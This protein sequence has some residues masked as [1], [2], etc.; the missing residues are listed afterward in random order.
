VLKKV[1]IGILV[2]IILAAAGCGIYIY[3]LDWNKHKTV[4]AQRFSQ[5]T[6]LK[7]VIDGS[8]EVQLFP[9]PKISAKKIQFFKNSGG[10]EPLV[11][12][13]TITADVDLM[14]LLDNK[15]IVKSMNLSQ[16]NVFVNVDEKGISNWSGA[17]KNSTKSNNAEVSFN[18]ITLSNSTI[19]YNNKQNGNAFSIP[20]IS[21]DIS[22]PSLQGPYK[23]SGKFIHNNSELRFN[24]DIVNDKKL[25]A[26]MNISN[27]AS[28][29]KLIL[30]GSLGEIASG[31]FTFDT[32]SLLDASNIVF[33][34]ASVPD[35]YDEP[36]FVSFKYNYDKGILRLDNFTTKFGKNTAGSGSVIIKK[37]QTGK[38]IT[39]DF[40]MAQFDLSVLENLSK[41]LIRT[42]TSAETRFSGYKGVLNLKAGRCIYRK[43]EAQNL[44][45]G[46]SF[47]N[48]TLDITRFGIIMPGD[49]VIR[50]VGRV[51]LATFE[52]IFNQSFDSKDLRVFASVFGIDPAK[53]APQENRKSIFK[54]AK[55]DIKINGDLNMLKASVSAGEVDATSFKGNIGFVNKDKQ[56][57]VLA[58]IE[59]SKILFDKYL[60]PVPENMK[61]AGFKDK[62]VY[63][64]SLLPWNKALNVD[65]EVN[66]NEAVYNDIALK[67]TEIHFNTTQDKFELKKL[68]IASIAGAGI[69]LTFNAD[70]IYTDPFFDE[71]NYSIKTNNFPQFATQM[72]INTGDKP[73]FKR[74]VFA[75]QGVLS[76]SFDKFNLSSVQKF[77]D[78]EF[79]Y[80]GTVSKD[81]ATTYVDGDL[82]MKTSNFSQ[83]IKALNLDY[84]PDMPVTTF[85]LTGKVKG[86]SN[87]FGI[88]G[89]TSY[90][91]A[92][93]I[94]GSI[95]YDATLLTPALTAMLDFDKFDADRLFN[96]NKKGFFE[97]KTATVPGL[98]KPSNIENP[99][100]YSAL[101]KIDFDIKAN[102]KSLIL[103]NQTYSDVQ[104]VVKLNNGVL[105][106]SSFKGKK[107]NGSVDLHFILNSGSMP[108]IDGYFNVKE[109]KTSEL[110]GTLYALESGWLDAEGTF[111]SF[112]GSVKDFLDNLNAKGKFTLNNT[113][114]RGWDLDIIKFELEQ[115]KSLAGFEDNVLNSLKT[116]KSSFSKIR[117]TYAVSKGIVVADSIAWES[118][119][120]QMKTKLNL[121]LSDWQ[122]KADFDTIYQNASFSDVLRFSLSGG[123]DSPVTT[124]DLSDS[125]KRIGEL[126]NTA[127]YARERADKEKNKRLRAKTEII[128]QDTA[129]TLQYVSRMALDVVR[130][131]PVS[132]ASNV[133]AVYNENLKAIAASETNIRKLQNMLN[134]YPDENTLEKIEKELGAERARIKFIP[135]TLE[136]NFVVDSKYI[137][138]DT[139]NKIAWLFNLAENNSAYHKS[140]TDA[141]LAQIAQQQGGEAEVSE[142]TIDELS[143]EISKIE[144]INGNIVNLHSKIRDNYL[145]IIDTVK[146]SEMK[147]N[148]EIADQALT[149]MLTYAKQL[150]EDIVNN[151][152]HFR[153]VL[154][155][156][157]KDYDTYL[158]YPPETTAEVAQRIA[159]QK[160][161]D[162][163]EEELKLEMDDDVLAETEEKH[164]DVSSE[165]EDAKQKQKASPLEENKKKINNN[166]KEQKNEVPVLSKP[167]QEKENPEKDKET[168][169]TLI[170][171][172]P[173]TKTENFIKKEDNAK[174]VE[175][176]LLSLSGGLSELLEK[177][178]ALAKQQDLPVKIKKD[179]Q[180]ASAIKA[181]K[182]DTTTAE[183]QFA[184]N[185]MLNAVTKDDSSTV[186]D[187]VAP[188]AN[189]DAKPETIK[190]TDVVENKPKAIKQE[191]PGVFQKLIELPQTAANAL[192]NKTK[193]SFANITEKFRQSSAPKEIKVA[194]NTLN[195]AE[196]AIKP[197]SGL[198]NDSN[199]ATTITSSFKTNP[200]IAMKTDNIKAETEEKAY[201]LSEVKK[202]GFT[203]KQATT[204]DA[205]IAIKD[206]TPAISS[207]AEPQKETTEL[208]FQQKQELLKLITLP[209][210]EEKEPYNIS[211]E[212][213]V[214]IDK[215]KDRAS[216]QNQYVF[217][218]ETSFAEFSGT[219]G[220][221]MLKNKAVLPD[222]T[223]APQ[224]IFKT[225][226]K[227][228]IQFSG[229][230][231][232][233]IFLAVK[234]KF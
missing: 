21:A 221:N 152:E 130:Y 47:A 98:A 67:K 172:A 88:E 128:K 126:E 68:N 169:T 107:D 25:N 28:A 198:A 17:T 99:I 153:T 91:G 135:K 23:I 64:M 49:S 124:V 112:A 38:E 79:S 45:L 24:G 92:N 226:S 1:I 122:F 228:K 59:A 147:E 115:R 93:G 60:T 185:E 34:A 127:K 29:S 157:T 214:S 80:T 159:A 118:P 22:A 125:I 57:Y 176:A 222:E 77:G 204:N 50:T 170:V 233:A 183:T 181:V 111:S 100:D 232:K 116:R 149:T 61:N 165:K 16:A 129:S 108:K 113:A 223:K 78:A 167:Q 132:S 211:K 27:A 19:S 213:L 215:S 9:S 94:T 173:K 82:E 218:K 164:P 219:I 177:N 179:N 146:V 35:Y 134:N 234:D 197:F 161:A 101:K 225:D 62:F 20:N 70:K 40:D 105:D 145:S 193:S 117:G 110:G 171:S 66:I 83:F 4:V 168:A 190:V 141:F 230:S 84:T 96:L 71:L 182:T 89:L 187:F 86:Q 73:L 72:G 186:K 158:M 162:V 53:L 217:E 137:F 150:T 31:N 75:A 6:G 224:Y 30:D 51:N 33:G 56:T 123:L 188:K 109:I 229:E 216:S 97:K 178:S 154:G 3:T 12:V 120:V 206:E 5:I 42:H 55:A 131:K 208:A 196:P 212:A 10:R 37:D 151:I 203:K 209:G 144:K 74:K 155:I 14:P 81:K 121:N 195:A 11:E 63:Q 191:E 48:N 194:Q 207:A 46:L 36:L 189:D 13:T 139:F 201:L 175:T 136:E 180:K 220:K 39:A 43:A 192:I 133:N 52:Y 15:F 7:A 163:S 18:N 54:K 41:D 2:F 140:L 65:A 114:M 138:D 166:S 119:V 143:K 227:Q 8:L 200:L 32:R 76:G 87:L 58:D 210:F 44:N 199:D 231:H 95:K 148:N 174:T 69:N 142:E 90:L 104:T 184:A 202:E 160:S 156:T 85:T 102:T 205:V 26:K 103:G 106:V